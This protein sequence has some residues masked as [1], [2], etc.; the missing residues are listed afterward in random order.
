LEISELVISLKMKMIWRHLPDNEIGT[1]LGAEICNELEVTVSS[2]YQNSRGVGGAKCN[3][4]LT[5]L[6][7]EEN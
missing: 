1:I 3:C 2:G 5:G 6:I 7:V 4:T